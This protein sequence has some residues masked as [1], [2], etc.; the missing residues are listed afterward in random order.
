MASYFI[1]KN[2]NSQ[3]KNVHLWTTPSVIRPE[4]R[5]ERITIPG[6]SGELTL[7]EGED[8][9]ESYIQTV[10]ITVD[11]LANIPDVENWLT[12]ADE[13]TF[14]TQPH[15]KQNARVIGVVTLEK[16]SHN[17]NRWSGDVQFYCDPIKHLRES[18]DITLTENGAAIMNPGDL[19]AKPRITVTGSGAVTLRIDSNVLNI[20]ECE[21][22]WVVDSMNEW[23]I[24][25]GVPIENA[26]SGTFPV[27]PAGES[28]IQWTGNVTSLT[29]SP[30]WR[31][32]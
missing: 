22:G 9:F 5:V 4:E 23:I 25:D 13:V 26:C 7:T 28:I 8:I 14:S 16:I 1:W 3:N 27:I 32:L 11:G 10:K 21:S 19:A 12:G 15:L 6:R 24:A 30:E 20:P 31:F 18:Q 17:M 2:I 29:I